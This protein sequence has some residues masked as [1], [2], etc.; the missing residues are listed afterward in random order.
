M[1]VYWSQPIVKNIERALLRL[2][3]KVIVANDFESLPRFVFGTNETVEFFFL[4]L[5]SN[6][7]GQQSD[8]AADGTQWEWSTI[9]KMCKQFMPLADAVSTVA[10]ESWSVLCR[11]LRY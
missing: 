1:C 2:K 8:D 5:M 7:P 11:P 4:T 3:G 10:Q 6:Y 9:E